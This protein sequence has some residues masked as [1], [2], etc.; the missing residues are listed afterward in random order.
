MQ[1]IHFYGPN[2][3]YTY[4]VVPENI[5]TPPMEGFWFASPHPLGISVPRG[6]FDDPPSPQEFPRY[7]NMVFVVTFTIITSILN[8]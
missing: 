6:V 3:D 5:H 7:S 2:M 1:K 8:I 4:C